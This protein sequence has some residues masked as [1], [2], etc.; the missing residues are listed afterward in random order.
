MPAGF[1]PP[2]RLGTSA[3]ITFGHRAGTGCA[4]RQAQFTTCDNTF[5]SHC[6][7]R[8]NFRGDD[9]GIVNS[10]KSIN[11]LTPNPHG[12]AGCSDP[13]TAF[14]LLPLCL[15]FLLSKVTASSPPRAQIPK[16]IKSSIRNRDVQCV[17]VQGLAKFLFSGLTFPAKEGEKTCMK[18]V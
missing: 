13:D 17:Q 6:H 9:R 2:V 11:S 16:I 7:L 15:T 10:E 3:P 4:V 1:H 12:G 5:A 8:R 18:E 14:T